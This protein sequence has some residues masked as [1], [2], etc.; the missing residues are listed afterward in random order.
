MSKEK[1]ARHNDKKGNNIMCIHLNGQ[2]IRNKMDLL[3]AEVLGYDVVAVSETW[4]GEGDADESVK[5]KGYHDPVRKD[6]TQNRGGGDV[7]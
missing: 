2:S 7:P 1:N 6:R 3:E 5:I 4:R